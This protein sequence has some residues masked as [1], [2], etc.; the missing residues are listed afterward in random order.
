MVQMASTSPVTKGSTVTSWT[1]LHKVCVT[2][3]YFKK[4][5]KR[6]WK[7]RFGCHNN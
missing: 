1:Q 4:K 3:V 2:C 6:G 5:K 7:Q